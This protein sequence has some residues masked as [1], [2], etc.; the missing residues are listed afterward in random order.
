M[1]PA[2]RDV[3][4]AA[5]GGAVLLGV[6]ALMIFEFKPGNFERSIQW[7]IVFTPGFVP[8]VVISDWLVKRVPVRETFWLLFWTF[9]FAWYFLISLLALKLFRLIKARRNGSPASAE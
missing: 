2:S 3:R 1:A 5:L 7:V 8:A 6:A 9:N 4:W